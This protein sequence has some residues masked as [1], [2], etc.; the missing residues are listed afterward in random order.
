MWDW[1]DQH[2]WRFDPPEGCRVDPLLLDDL[3]EV[4]PEVCEMLEGG[5]LLEVILVWFAGE[6]HG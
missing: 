4:L 1:L 6:G 5:E 2:G 3:R